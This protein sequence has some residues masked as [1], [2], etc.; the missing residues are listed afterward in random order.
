MCYPVL[1]RAAT[2]SAESSCRVLE[3]VGVCCNTFDR[4]TQSQAQSTNVCV[5]VC[6][7]VL[8]RVAACCSVMQCVAMCCSVLQCV[9]VRCSV[10]QCVRTP[11]TARR[12]VKPS[13]SSK[14]AM[15]ASCAASA[16]STGNRSSCG[17][18]GIRKL[19]FSRIR[20][21]S[22]SCAVYPRW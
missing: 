21:G 13:R 7:S 17:N 6:C 8:Q 11:L 12:G 5:A 18:L 19:T 15:S 20:D 3:C 14:S 22:P 2:P 1:Q 10:L 4:A 9:A 16:R